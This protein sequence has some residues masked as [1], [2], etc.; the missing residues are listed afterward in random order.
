MTSISWVRRRDNGTQ[1]TSSRAML[2]LIA[3]KTHPYTDSPRAICKVH[4]RG[5]EQADKGE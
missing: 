1:L 4:I 3:L 2:Y 5:I